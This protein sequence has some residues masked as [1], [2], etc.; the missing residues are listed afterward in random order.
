MA[1]LRI[2]RKNELPAVLQPSTM[3]VVR[4]DGDENMQLYFTGESSGEVRHVITDS[5]VSAAI[6]D[7]VRKHGIEVIDELPYASEEYL[8]KMYCVTTLGGVPCW[9]DGTKWIDLTKVAGT[10]GGVVSGDVGVDKVARNHLWFGI[11]LI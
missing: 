2:E 3:Y 6:A 9:C 5:E 4:G 1:E 7:A 8:G 11:K 10:G